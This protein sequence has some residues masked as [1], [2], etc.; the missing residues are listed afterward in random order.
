MRGT[1]TR[2]ASRIEP[3]PGHIGVGISKHAFYRSAQERAKA[4]H[5]SMRNHH[6][7]N[8]FVA[9]AAFCSSHVL[10]QPELVEIEA[11]DFYF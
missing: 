8:G 4:K 9:A 11:R 10:P 7:F 6:S 2:R 3:E 1:A 5:T